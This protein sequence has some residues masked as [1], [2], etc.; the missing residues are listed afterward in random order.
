MP[1]PTRAAF[2]RFDK[3][4]MADIVEAGWSDMAIFP[5]ADSPGHFFN[6]SVGLTEVPHPELLIVGLDNE[7]MHGVLWSAVR[8]IKDHG[9]RF[10]P[11]TF[12]SEVLMGMDVAFVKVEDLHDDRFMMSMARRLYGDKATGLQIVWPD[13]EGRFPWH[14]DFNPD[15][16]ERQPLAGTW[17]GPL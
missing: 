2:D 6:Y 1:R 17:E 14:D 16:R 13:T 10:E 8:R 12:S 4:V 11:N 9:D 15:Y 5:T 7:Q 3:K